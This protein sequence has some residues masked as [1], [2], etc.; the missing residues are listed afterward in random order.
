MLEA[1]Q[2]KVEVSKVFSMEEVVQAH[3]LIET[4]GVRGKVV[5][6]IS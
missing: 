2:L 3:H 6:K 4:Q 5:I 1:G